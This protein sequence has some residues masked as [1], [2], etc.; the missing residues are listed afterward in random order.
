M[1][2]TKIRQEQMKQS[3]AYTDTIGAGEATLVTASTDLEFDANAIRSQIKRAYGG[4]N[5]YDDIATVNGKKRAIS[6]LNTGL[7]TIETK[8]FFA[9]RQV[10]TDITVATAENFVGL[11]VAGNAAPTQT[12]GVTSNGAIVAVLAA[13]EF[14]ANRLTEVVGANALSPKNLVFI[15]DAGTKDA[16][17]SGEYQVY[18][19]LQ[20]ENGVV[21]GDTFNDTTK[22]VQISFVINSGTDTLV[23]C[24]V[25]DIQGKTIEYVYSDRVNFEDLPEDSSFPFVTFGDI[26]LSG[27]NTLSQVMQN[28]GATPVVSTS[29]TF[30]KISDGNEFT[31]QNSDAS[32]DIFRV[33][34]DTLA[35]AQINRVNC[36]A[37]LTVESGGAFQEGIEVDS[38]DQSI[39]IG[40]TAGQIDSAGSLSLL[41]TGAT[42]DVSIFSSGGILFNDKHITASTYTGNL[43]LATTTQE[44]TDFVNNYGSVSLISAINTASNTGNSIIL[45]ILLTSDV[46]NTTSFDPNTQT[47]INSA[48]IPDWTTNTISTAVI[49]INGIRKIYGSA[50]DF[51]VG[52]T[53]ADGQISFS[54]NLYSGDV[55]TI[56]YT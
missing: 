3:R 27:D 20:A 9:F 5:W 40:V 47:N 2:I 54:S 45:E 24:P 22:R 18:G 56:E 11:S 49:Y 32:V 7:D 48:A 52:T 55:I 10:I 35:G 38:N 8:K 25:A 6:G 39:Q 13:A 26:A 36:G 31:F 12:A 50:Y 17:R 44:I 37:Y 1:A 46:A 16:I 41:T 21:Q 42:S 14:G 19:L 28:Q 4:S 29:N 53:A 51:Q 30:I 15:R 33:R 43:S 23:A 34:H